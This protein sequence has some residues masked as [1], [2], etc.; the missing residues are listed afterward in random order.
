MVV[1]LGTGRLVVE[2]PEGT[3]AFDVSKGFLQVVDNSVSAL[4]ESV[5]PA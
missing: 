2:G 4:A 1:L 5:N 3:H